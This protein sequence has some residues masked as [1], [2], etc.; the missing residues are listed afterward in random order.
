VASGLQRE[1]SLN[2][3]LSLYLLETLAEQATTPRARPGALDLL[4]LV[5]SI[6]E[7]PEVVLWAQVDAA[8]GREDPRAEGARRRVR[9]A[10]D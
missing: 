4:T 9:P 7:S 5:E 1:F 8:E 10:H 6:L 2:H 3:T